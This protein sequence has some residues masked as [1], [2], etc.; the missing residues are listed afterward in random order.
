MVI[1]SVL[2]GLLVVGLVYGLTYEFENANSAQKLPTTTTVKGVGDMAGLE[3]TT[4]VEKTNYSLGE[5]VN[6]T[7]A[8]TNISN[9]TTTVSFGDSNV[10][11]DFQVFDNMNST[12][13]N[14]MDN[15]SYMRSILMS[16]VIVYWY[17]ETRTQIP[18]VASVSLNAG[19]NLTET[20]VWGQTYCTP[21]TFPDENIAVSAGTYYVV[22]ISLSGTWST[23]LRTPPI[24][25][26]I[27]KT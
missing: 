23:F 16:N 19:E 14:N 21:R 1:L 9:Q 17:L 13:Y 4:T 6:I 15:V 26:M 18:I 20:F 10:Y 5:P 7:L 8:I 25:I 3:L 24:E 11:F 2:V 22:G 12:F 27:N